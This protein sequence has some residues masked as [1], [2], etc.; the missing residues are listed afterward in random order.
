LQGKQGRA[1]YS[2]LTVNVPGVSAITIC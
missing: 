1:N 2:G